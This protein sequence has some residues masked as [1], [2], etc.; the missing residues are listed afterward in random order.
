MAHFWGW[1]VFN[2]PTFAQRLAK[3]KYLTVEMEEFANIYCTDNVYCL[4]NKQH[5]IYNQ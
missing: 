3:K 5:H 4:N 1:D 2:N